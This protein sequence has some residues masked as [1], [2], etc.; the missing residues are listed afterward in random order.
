MPKSP[1]SARLSIRTRRE[2][3]PPNRPKPLKTRTYLCVGVERISFPQILGNFNHLSFFPPPF[4]FA[5]M[6]RFPQP[7][8]GHPALVLAPMEGVTDAPMRAVQT[9]RGAFAFCVSEF[10]RVCRD[11]VPGKVFLRHIPELEHG[12]KTP[13]GIPI[14][15]QLLGGDARALGWAAKRAEELGAQAIDLNFGCPAPTV[16]R[17]DGGATLLKFPHRIREIVASVRGA[18]SP[19]IAVS[20]KL[21]LGWDDIQ[22]IH[23]NAEQAALGGADWIT[24]HGRTRLAGYRPP[25][26]WEPIGEVRRRLHPLPVIAN[27][28]IWNI[29]DFRRC[30][31]VTGCEHFM[32]GRGALADPNLPLSAARELGIGLPTPVAPFG[33][34][35]RDWLPL[36]ERFDRHFGN[37]PHRSHYLARRI[38]QWTKYAQLFGPID[39]FDRIK[40]LDTAEE[41][42]GVL[43]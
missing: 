43:N 40:R 35:P 21:R 1:R 25:I 14:Q 39:W 13:S 16:N 4:K 33:S 38:K 17:N 3:A 10:L 27:G 26:F 29:D 2:Q 42:Y 20:A 41:I 37:P 11:E 28:D 8:A 31:D 9:E 19:S 5:A 34:N 22:S 18:V 36:F 15:V 6:E 32:L 12:C 30:R 23:E 7:T 24:I